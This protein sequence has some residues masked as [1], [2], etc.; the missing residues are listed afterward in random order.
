MF[1]C[2]FTSVVYVFIVH[3]RYNETQYNTLVS[4]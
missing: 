1:F 4:I 2:V 3:K